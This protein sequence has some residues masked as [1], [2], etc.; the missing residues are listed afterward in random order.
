MSNSERKVLG[1]LQTTAIR[2]CFNSVSR[3]G[4][5]TRPAQSSLLLTG[6]GFPVANRIQVEKVK[7][8]LGREAGHS[9]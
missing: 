3:A 7:H 9:H 6:D 1:A 8:L 2:C 5:L 4:R